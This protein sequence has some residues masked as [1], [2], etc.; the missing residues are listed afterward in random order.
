MSSDWPAE[1]LITPTFAEHA[2]KTKLTLQHAVGS[3]P[4]SERDVCQQ[5]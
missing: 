2:G 4:A 3:G 1:A 5:C